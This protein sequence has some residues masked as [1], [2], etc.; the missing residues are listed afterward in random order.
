MI[1][2]RRD[3]QVVD[4]EARWSMGFQQQIQSEVDYCRLYVV[5]LRTVSL[6]L[7]CCTHHNRLQQ[8]YETA[9]SLPLLH[10][11]FPQGLFLRLFQQDVFITDILHGAVQLRLDITSTLKTK[12]THKHAYINKY[13]Y[14]ITCINKL[15]RLECISNLPRLPLHFLSSLALFFRPQ[16]IFIWW[17]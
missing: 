7:P 10:K 4:E 13:R 2:Y 15:W 14:N 3:I 16:H 5:F 11:S 9:E 17:R 12:W 6:P 8:G 1:V